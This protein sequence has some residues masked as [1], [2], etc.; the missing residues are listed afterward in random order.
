MSPIAARAATSSTPD[1]ARPR[2]SE[3]ATTAVTASAERA[4]WT[5]PACRNLTATDVRASETSVAT[6]AGASGANTETAAAAATAAGEAGAEVKYAAYS[7]ADR[8]AESAT[9]KP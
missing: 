8:S 4:I 6:A 2:A 5:A 3:A 1:E 9:P 7:G